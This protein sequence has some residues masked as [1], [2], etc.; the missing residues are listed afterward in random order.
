MMS[1]IVKIHAIHMVKDIVMS[2]LGAAVFIFGFI[3]SIPLTTVA[4]EYVAIYGTYFGVHVATS[5]FT[6]K[7][8][9][10]NP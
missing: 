4:V 2:A 8:L 9:K 7:N 5:A 10:V 1:D 6:A 3:H